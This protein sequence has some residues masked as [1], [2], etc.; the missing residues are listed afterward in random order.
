MINTKIK[1]RSNI[2]EI[3]RGLWKGVAVPNLMYGTEIIDIGTKK[4]STRTGSSP[5]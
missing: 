2:Y 3:T 1:F 4:K 5:K